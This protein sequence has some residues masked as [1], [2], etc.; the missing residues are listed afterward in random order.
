[1]Q[2]STTHSRCLERPNFLHAYAA[3]HD[4]DLT[5]THAWPFLRSGV[6]GEDA[7]RCCFLGL[8]LG[9]LLRITLGCARSDV[10]VRHDVCKLCSVESIYAKAG[11]SELQLAVK[12]PSQLRSPAQPQS[13]LDACLTGVSI[14]AV[15]KLD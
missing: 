8:L 10:V 9:L 14:S 5:Y 3:S 15:T 6:S 13:H 2:V 11:M 7:L 1:M 12:G 4:S